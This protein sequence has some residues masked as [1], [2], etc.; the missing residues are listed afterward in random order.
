MCVGKDMTAM[1]A[2]NHSGATTHVARQSRVRRRIDILR[3]DA[4]A[5]T[6]SRW[7]IRRAFGRSTAMKNCLHVALP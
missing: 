4:L 2:L 3:P 6:K 5:N 1:E 7:I